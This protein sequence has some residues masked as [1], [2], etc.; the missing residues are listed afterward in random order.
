MGLV[1]GANKL[2]LDQES[3]ESALTRFSQELQTARIEHFVFFG[4]LLGLTRDLKPING[5]DDVD[6]YVNGVDYEKVRRLLA[7]MGLHID[8]SSYPNGTRHFIQVNGDLDG[9]KIRVDFYFYNAVN[10]NNFL[11]EAWNFDG[12][13]KNPNTT[14]KV[15]KPL[16]FPLE[17]LSFRGQLIS[18]PK[19]REIICEFLYGIS[20][21]TPKQKNTDYRVGILGGRP[22]RFKP[23]DNGLA[24]ID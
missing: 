20:W 9:H 2:S 12:N 4:T 23:N 22:I 10:D 21:R 19:H 16:V 8:Y 17:V 15:P 13:L 14:L 11:L 18:A 6:F 1:M 3:M 5:D 24:L 7:S